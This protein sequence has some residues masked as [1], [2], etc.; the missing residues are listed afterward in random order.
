MFYNNN[1]TSVYKDNMVSNIN[2][3]KFQELS[4]GHIFVH[5][6]MVRRIE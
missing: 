2:I 6:Y 1:N 5:A 4:H 3:D